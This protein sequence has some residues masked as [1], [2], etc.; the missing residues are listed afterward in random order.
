MDPSTLDIS[1]QAHAY[2][3]AHLTLRSMLSFR[4]MSECTFLIRSTTWL[5]LKRFSFTNSYLAKNLYLLKILIFNNWRNVFWVVLKSINFFLSMSTKPLLIAPQ[6]VFR[7]AK[8]SF[9]NLSKQNSL[10]W[11][12]VTWNERSVLYKWSRK[13]CAQQHKILLAVASCRLKIRLSL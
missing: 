1:F 13:R 10:N 7:A 4:W 9:A 11:Q 12:S 3:C 2:P 6:N 5:L 8:L